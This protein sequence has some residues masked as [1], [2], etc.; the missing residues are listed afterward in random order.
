MASFWGAIWPP[1]WLKPLLEFLLGWSRAVQEHFFRSWSHQ[2]ALQ[3]ASQTVPRGLREA[4]MLQEPSREPF[5]THFASILDP[6]WAQKQPLEALQ[7][8]VRR[9]AEEPPAV[10]QNSGSARMHWAGHWRSDST[11]A[12]S[13]A[14][15]GCHRLSPFNIWGRRHE[16]SASKFRSELIWPKI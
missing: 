6:N 4:K 2:R 8:A 14:L 13:N 7:T 11:V 16:A 12:T 9:P 10:L 15:S 3:E 1:R 5:G